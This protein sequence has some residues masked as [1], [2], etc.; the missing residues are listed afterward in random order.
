MQMETSCRRAFSVGK[1]K[2]LVSHSSQRNEERQIRI[3]PLNSLIKLEERVV[4]RSE[5]TFME[6]EHTH[7]KHATFTYERERCALDIK[8][9]LARAPRLSARRHHSEARC[10]EKDSLLF[11]LC[12]LLPL[13][14][15]QQAR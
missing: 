2:N 12:Q 13:D 3:H 9:E 6:N 4:K 7:F 10:Q 15:L 1:T 5:G 8:S 11:S 14:F